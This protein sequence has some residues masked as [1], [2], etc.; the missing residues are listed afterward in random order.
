[1]ATTKVLHNVHEWLREHSP[2]I[3]E[4]GLP[5]RYSRKAPGPGADDHRQRANS[6][7]NQHRDIQQWF[8]GNKYQCDAIVEDITTF[9]Q[10]TPLPYMKTEQVKDVIDELRLGMVFADFLVDEAGLQ[11][12]SGAGSCS[13]WHLDATR[14]TEHTMREIIRLRNELVISIPRWTVVATRPHLP[15]L[16]LAACIY[17]T[18]PA[19][20]RRKAIL[21]RIVLL[22]QRFR[23]VR[24]H[25]GYKSPE[26]FLVSR[27]A[28]ANTVSGIDR[29]RLLISETKSRT[30]WNLEKKTV[31][32]VSEVFLKE[33]RWSDECG[34]I[35]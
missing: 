9:A 34:N 7:V 19:R 20:K 26:D 13:T 5:H 17:E 10:G 27:P 29:F 14:Y 30:S 12:A 18:D 8:F 1:M 31:P 11:H 22:D 15:F 3:L 16:Y 25:F 2:H 6:L 21:D 35:V 33:I 32:T 28:N 4:S 23:A 24:T